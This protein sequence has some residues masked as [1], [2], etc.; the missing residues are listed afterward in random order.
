[1]AIKTSGA[2][3]DIFTKIALVLVVLIIGFLILLPLANILIYSTQP[4]GS[5]ILTNSWSDIVTR[6][7]IWN[8]VKLGLTV[9]FLGTLLGFIMAYTQA[10]V[11]F[12]GK[13]V[14]HI[15]NLIPI[16][17]PPFAFA[18][19]VIVLF[20]RSGIITRGVFDWRPT[21]Y[22]FTGL[23][24]VLTLSYFPIAYMNLLGM[25]RSLD[26]ALDEA[27]S[28]LGANKW[29][30]FKTVTLPLLI[31]G[32][33]GS[34]LLL[35]IEAI[36]DLGNPIIIGGNY[37]VL[38]SRAYMAINGDY[39]ISLAAGY[40]TLLLLPALLVFL[41]QRY[42]AQKRSVVSVTGKPSGRP[43][44]VTSKPAKFFLLSI[45]GL[46]TSLVILVYLTVVFG[47]FVKIIGV[48]NEFTLDNFRYLLSGFA[49]GAIKT[50]ATLALIAT[51]L[52]GI[53]GMVIAW[54]VIRKVRR[55]AEALDFLGMLGI[56]VPGT[57][58][59]IGYAITYNDP[60][61]IGDFTVF[62]QVGGGGAILGGAIAIVMVYIIRSSPAGQRSGIS[63][64]QQIDPAIEEASASLGAAGGK[65]FRLI[66]LPLISGAYLSG[67]MYAFAHSMTTLSP[68]IFLVT[69]DTSILTQKILAEA[70]QGRYGNV[71]ALCCIL[72][73]LIMVIGGLI[74]LLVRKTQVSV[75]RPMV[76]G[77]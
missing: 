8:T 29:R 53:F 56:A 50:T 36:A 74:N 67:L 65:T 4:S 52:A 34:F 30:V 17:S 26:P 20:G 48:N 19:A 31:P 61:K 63:Q 14:L 37:T 12:R 77:R 45:T 42:W 51:P 33:A 11:E 66:T 71:F 35:F 39:D 25:L 62:P 76:T 2:K 24:L 49:N 54:L 1:M 38:A 58:I 41:I 44:M 32:F 22:G 57:V 46:L 18:T 64:L 21:L 47:A 7:I 9:A 27:G 43:T 60:V 70:D 10:R 73:V 69:P 28:S 40:S 5:A 6:E 72:I 68:I 3:Y 16:I 55:G 75:D 13:K 15:I 23:V 59:G